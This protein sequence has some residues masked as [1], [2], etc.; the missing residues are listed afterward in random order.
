[1]HEKGMEIAL[2]ADRKRQENLESWASGKDITFVGPEAE[3]RY[4]DRVRL[5]IDAIQM[6]K[7]P[8]RVP[9]CP[10]AGYFALENDRQPLGLYASAQRCR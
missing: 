3:A 2:D 10:V 8:R 4:R 5:I 6:K 9:V 7:I 1:M